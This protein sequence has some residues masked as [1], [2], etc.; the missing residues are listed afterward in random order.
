VRSDVRASAQVP[1][2][3]LILEAEDGTTHI[4]YDLSS[5]T[6]SYLH[7]PGIEA[8]VAPLDDKL[9]AFMTDLAGAGTE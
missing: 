8:A 4:A 3:V 1:L 5:T 2:E 7:N 9:V 6:V